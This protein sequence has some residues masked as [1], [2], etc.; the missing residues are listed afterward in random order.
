MP[1]NMNQTCPNS[2]S[3]DFLP[4]QAIMLCINMWFADPHGNRKAWGVTSMPAMWWF[5]AASC[6]VR[7]HPS[8]TCAVSA[9]RM[10]EP[11]TWPR[12]THLNSVLLINHTHVNVMHMQTS[13]IEKSHY[14]KSA[15][16]TLTNATNFF[17]HVHHS[18]PSFCR[19][20][21]A[22]SA[23]SCH[24]RFGWYI[25]ISHWLI[26]SVKL[27]QVQEK[28]ADLQIVQKVVGFQQQLLIGWGWL[29]LRSHCLTAVVPSNH[30]WVQ[31]L[32]KRQ[33]SC[34]PRDHFESQRARSVAPSRTKDPSETEKFRWW[35]HMVCIH[36]N[37]KYIVQIC[38]INT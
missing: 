26:E 28:S 4:S 20:P 31:M 8:A 36:I 6:F 18:H 21:I 22:S 9:S 38:W 15:W 34:Y 17:T 1:E 37:Q 7:N 10:C 11:T 32:P 35:S 23:H 30:V 29:M 19:A 25:W 24:W 13:N 27:F 3:E 5:H 2:E 16:K 33:I 12:T 14:C